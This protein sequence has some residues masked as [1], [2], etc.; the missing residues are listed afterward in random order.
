M[1]TIGRY[2]ARYLKSLGP[3]TLTEEQQQA[4]EAYENRNEQALSEEQKQRRLEYQKKVF[5]NKK[6][7]QIVLSKR[8]I[9]SLFKNYYAQLNNIEFIQSNEALLN[10]QPIVNYFAQSEDFYKSERLTDI[11][12]PSLTKGLLIIGDYGNGKSSI[13][14]AMSK[15]LMA[16]G[17]TFGF[18]NMNDVVTTYEECESHEEKKT[19]WHYH[20]H[21]DCLFD[22]VKTERDASNYGK[23]NLFKDI[24]EKR[25]LNKNIITHITCNYASGKGGNLEAGMDE[26]GIMY[27]GRVYDRMSEMFNVIEFKGKSMRS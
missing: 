4:L 8:D 27:G 3:D 20:T 9:W 11:Y 5:E 16:T 19:F 2:A 15:V 25:Y 13:M 21:S 7:E 1:E 22:D 12:K 26:F 24:L 10:I 6:E 23:V 18:K 17:K 14:Q